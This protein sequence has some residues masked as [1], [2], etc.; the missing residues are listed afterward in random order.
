VIRVRTEPELQAAVRRLGSRQTIL[1][2]PGTYKLRSTLRI[3]SGVKDAAIRG[4]TGSHDDVVLIGNGMAKAEHGG[5]PHG[6]WIGNAR[7]VLIANVTIRDVYYHAIQLDPGAGA[8]APRIHNVR[9]VDSG[10]QFIKASRTP[11][12]KAV[13]DGVVEY[14]VMEYTSTARSHYTNGVDVLGGANWIVR[15]NLF[16]NIRAPAGQ[17]A[18]PAVLMWMGSKNSVVEDNVLINVQYGIALGLDPGR[19][20]DHSG[21]IVRNNFFHRSR[22]QSGDVGITINN[23]ASTK[24]LHNTVILSGTYPNAIEYRF[25]ATT[26]VEIRYN[27]TDAAVRA[28]DGATGAVSD[29]VTGAEPS[30]F[31]DAAAGDLHL[32]KTAGEAIDRAMPHAEVSADLDGDRRPSG[33]APDMGAD[34]LVARPAVRSP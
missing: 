27:L 15:G 34:E 29:N 18:G 4:R 12:G 30:W 19:P 2:E 22:D 28:R 25:P 21:G 8:Q 14:S 20:D 32:V 23:S 26:G 1:L 5:V 6:I 11:D 13:H 9:L 10:E 33:A 24:V 3:D 31:A 7:R 17:L 16:K